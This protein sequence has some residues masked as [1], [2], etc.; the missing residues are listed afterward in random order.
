MSAP[1]ETTHSNHSRRERPLS[2]QSGQSVL[3]ELHTEAADRKWVHL[4][5]VK[6]VAIGALRPMGMHSLILFD[7][8]VMSS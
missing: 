2:A 7:S 8:A 4:C 6:R 5:S 3:C 1:A